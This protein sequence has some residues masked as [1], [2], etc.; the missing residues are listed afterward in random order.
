MT[1]SEKRTPTK[2]PG[3]PAC[4]ALLRFLPIF[5]APGFVF[6][7]F[8]GAP[9]QFAYPTLVPEAWA[10]HDA[11]LEHGWVA[12]FD[13]PAWQD[14]AEAYV[15]D[16]S[17]LAAADLSTLQKLL[18]LHVRKERFCTGHLLDMF[19]RGHITAILKRLETITGRPTRSV[20]RPRTS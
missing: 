19:E 13:W 7:K 16:A 8:E 17:K 10:F 12:P 3:R 14:E 18:T 1:P 15:E 6:G 9:G 5:E 11:L 4:D 20:G 2:T